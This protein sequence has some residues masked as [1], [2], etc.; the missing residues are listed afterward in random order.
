MASVL[1]ASVPARWRGELECSRARS[2]GSVGLV[3]LVA[4]EA[5][6]RAV[7]VDRFVDIAVDQRVGM[8]HQVLADQPAGLASPSGKRPEAELSSSRGVP[9]PLQATMTICRL[10]LLDAVGVVVDHAVAMPSSPVVISRTRQLVR[11]S[12]PARM[13]CG[14]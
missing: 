9:T 3:E 7:P 8:E 13:A 10:E 1:T 14:Q 6:R 5:E 4:Q 11:S 12:T 2:R